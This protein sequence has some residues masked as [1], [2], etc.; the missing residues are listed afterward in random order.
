MNA[1]NYLFMRPAFF[2]VVFNPFLLYLHC[3]RMIQQSLEYKELRNQQIMCARVCVFCGGRRG[4]GNLSQCGGMLG[5]AISV[6]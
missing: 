2:D 3:I 5:G 4:R 6:W 1:Q